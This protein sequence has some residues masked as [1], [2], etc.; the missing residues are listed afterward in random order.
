MGFYGS[1]PWLAALI[2]SNAAGWISDG[3]V[4]KGLSTG[5]ARRTLIYAGA[6][7][8][9]LCLRLST[10]AGNA[11]TAVGLITATILLAGLTLPAYW[12]LPMDMNV[13]KAGFITGIMNT[14]S[15]LAAI[16]APGMT[17]FIVMWFGWTAA[18]GVGSILAIL[19]AVIMF[20]AARDQR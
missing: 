14:G 12:S 5:S 18:L 15:A 4:R 13:G 3:L 10:Q 2:S 17:G 1:L 9:A 19:S 6:P 16:V 8:M 11:E 20:I 7:A